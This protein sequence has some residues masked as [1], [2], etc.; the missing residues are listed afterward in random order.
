MSAR[1]W[2]RPAF[3]YVGAQRSV[4]A[5]VAVVA[6]AVAPGRVVERLGVG[7]VERRELRRPA[8]VD[9]GRGGLGGADLRRAVG[10]VAERAHVAVAVE[11]A[12]ATQPGGAPAEPGDPEPLEAL[13][14]R[15]Q[16][17]EPEWLSG[18]GDVVLAHRSR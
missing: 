6:E 3:R 2:I 14:E 4:I 1:P 12:I 7:Q 18:P 15:P 17:I 9:E 13:R 16:L 10:I 8:Q 11:P 5:Q